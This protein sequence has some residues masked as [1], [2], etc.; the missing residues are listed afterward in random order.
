MLDQVLFKYLAT[1]PTKVAMKKLGDGYF[2]FGTKRIYIKLD[3]DLHT[4][5]VRVG[6]KEFITLS[7]FIIENEGIEIQKASLGKAM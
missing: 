7:M 6:P 4:L 2:K 1:R 5:L 3:N